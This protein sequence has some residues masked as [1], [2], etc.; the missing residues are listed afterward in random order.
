MTK[1][2]VFS[3]P[4]MTIKI[5]GNTRIEL[6]YNRRAVKKNALHFLGSSIKQLARFIELFSDRKS[7]VLTVAPADQI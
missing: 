6:A 4:W 2:T 5:A 3:I 7:D 1:Q